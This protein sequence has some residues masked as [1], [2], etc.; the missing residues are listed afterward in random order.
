MEVRAGLGGLAVSGFATEIEISLYSTRSVEA[1]LEI[2]DAIGRTILAVRLDELK[3][4]LFWLPVTPR[5]LK[6]VEVRLLTNMGKVIKQEISF[7]QHRSPFTIISR[8]IPV[9]KTLNNHQLPMDI[10]PLILSSKGLPHTPQAYAGISS[11]I[12]DSQSLSS[13]TQDQYRALGDYLGRCNI[14]LIPTADPSRL[15]ALQNIAGCRGHFIHSFDDL[16]QVTAKLLKLASLQP[17]KLPGSR[18]LLQLQQTGFQQQMI[19][20]LS[21][22][23]GGYILLFILLTWRLKNTNYLL[24]MPVFVA[25]AGIL[26]WTG[27]GAHQM[28]SWTET[29]SGENHRR[30]SSLLLLGGNR[31]GENTVVLGSDS[32]LYNVQSESQHPTI[33]YT[34]EG[35]QRI[36]QGHTQLFSQQTYRLTSVN[37]QASPF[38]LKL[39]HN[40]PTVTLRSEKSTAGSLLLWRGKSYKVPLL[41]KGKSWQPE[42]IQGHHPLTSAER[43]LNRRLAFGDPALLVPYH[44]GPIERADADIQSSGW[45]VIRRD[46]G[47]LL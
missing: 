2:V 10:S 36:L 24:L 41:T 12:T 47:Q 21:L 9:D 43:L 16:T 33:R 27:G 4:K 32:Y 45:L 39:E 23:L 35:S 30:V 18:D 28:I 40:Q 44:S 29:V 15:Q 26:A 38:S 31:R 19:G 7:K 17:P 3:E 42:E 22:Y 11:I 6:P 1:E 5:P 13:L 14:M 20:S 37:R 46:A 8:S 34:Q 25:T